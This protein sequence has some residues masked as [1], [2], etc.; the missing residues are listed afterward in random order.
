MKTSKEL[1][2]ELEALLKSE[3]EKVKASTEWQAFIQKVESFWNDP[4]QKGTS[5]EIIDGIELASVLP[6]SIPKIEGDYTEK[7][8]QFIET[9]IIDELFEG[10]CLKWHKNKDAFICDLAI[11]F[12]T[13]NFSDPSRCYAI[14]GY[15][16]QIEY[17]AL[18]ED[19]LKHALFLIEKNMRK[20]GGFSEIVQLDYYGGVMR[21]LS[22][23]LGALS[24][25]EL[26]EYG[27]QFD[28]KEK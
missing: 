14:D 20:H 3:A 4:H 1:R 5:R 12:Y 10:T 11:D 25:E 24:D 19:K 18:K 8:R 27:K 21:E 7:D 6:V 28:E 17:K 23:D 2:Q 22:T 26:H 9:I 13:V 15:D 16:L